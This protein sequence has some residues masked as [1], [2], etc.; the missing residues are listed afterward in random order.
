MTFLSKHVRDCIDACYKVVTACE[1]CADVSPDDDSRERVRSCADLAAL[2]LRF[3]D[4]QSSLA[5]DL[6]VTCAKACRACAHTCIAIETPEHAQAALACQRCVD[7]LTD[8]ALILATLHTPHLV[9]GR[10]Q[11]VSVES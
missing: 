8:N 7:V 4:R 2:T 11:R 3:L 9:P 5:S 1:R 10:P 6:A